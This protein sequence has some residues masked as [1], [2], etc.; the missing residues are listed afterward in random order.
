MNININFERF[1][2]KLDPNELLNGTM[3]Q[4][5]KTSLHVKKSQ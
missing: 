1:E 5:Y 2:K 3:K 4:S